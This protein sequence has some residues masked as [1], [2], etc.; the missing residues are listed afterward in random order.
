MHRPTRAKEGCVR[1]LHGAARKRTKRQATDSAESKQERHNSK[2]ISLDSHAKHI[3]EPDLI[4]H[5]VAHFQNLFRISS[6]HHTPTHPPTHLPTHLPTKSVL[7]FDD[8]DV[9]CVHH[10]WI[11]ATPLTGFIKIEAVLTA[12]GLNIHSRIKLKWRQAVLMGWD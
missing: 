2:T 7:H 11:A 1:G 9:W 10:C 6:V 3:S 5:S 4:T 8:G 12:A